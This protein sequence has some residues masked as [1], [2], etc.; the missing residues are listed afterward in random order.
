[1]LNIESSVDLLNIL[2]EAE[3]AGVKVINE[4]LTPAN[5]ENLNIILKRFLE[6]EG[7]NCQIL[8]NLIKHSGGEP[9]K[10]TGDFVG[11]VQAISDISEKINMLVKGQEWV[12]KIIR[13]CRHL[14][15]GGSNYLFLEAIK[16]QHEQNIEELKNYSASFLLY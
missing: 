10:R 11:K 5:K 6:D 8:F 16:V 4:L 12:S 14:F 7:M 3:R 15:N 1:M 9:S 13:K 2:L